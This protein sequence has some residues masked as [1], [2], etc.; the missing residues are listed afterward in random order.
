MAAAA[1]PDTLVHYGFDDAQVDTGPDTFA[2]FENAKGRVKLSDALRYSGYRAVEIRDVSRDGDFPELQGYFPLRD[3]GRLYAHFAIL[4][5]DPGENL[6]IALAGPRWFQLTRDGIA[7]WLT[8]R[9][10]FLYQYSDSMPKRLFA[11]TPFVW[12]RVDLSYDIDAG[13]YDLRVFEENRSQPLVERRDQINAANKP[14]SRIDKFSFI[15]D[16]GEDT[17]NVVY[18][19]DDVLIGTDQGIV[20]AP[21]IAP[22]RRKLFIDYWNDYQHRLRE[23]LACLPATRIE[24][25]GMDAAV[26]AQIRRQRGISPIRQINRDR[27]FS[28]QSLQALPEPTRGYATAVWHWKQGCR[29]LDRGEFEQAIARFE[30]ALALVSNG[31][32][33]ELSLLLAWAATGTTEQVD[34]RLLSLYGGWIDD[35]RFDIAI[36]MIAFTRR[37]VLVAESLSPNL[38]RL[39]PRADKETLVWALLEGTLQAQM[40]Q[41]LGSRTTVDRYKAIEPYLLME[42]VYFLH[43]WRRRYARAGAYAAD[44]IAHLR[45]AGLPVT[46]WQERLGDAALL[47]GDHARAIAAYEQSVQANPQ[48]SGPYT[49][50]SDVYFLLHDPG[51]ERHYREKVYGSLIN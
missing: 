29:A 10:G 25:F 20:D 41:M 34:S 46:V 12:Y 42:Q 23:R 5:T 11:P 13:R 14:G 44:V 15:G 3:S 30:D 2:V 48:R 31:R 19:V 18:Y 50:L 51:R 36:A 45:D 37:E 28:R 1:A 9:N 40:Y 4:I 27:S 22:G 38:P 17:S 49:K 33:F 6:N 16:R 32:I 47:A 21:L 35:P 8:T 24:D 26:L 39:A 43:L 7:F